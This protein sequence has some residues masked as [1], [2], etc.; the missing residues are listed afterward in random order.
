MKTRVE[1]IDT[2]ISEEDLNFRESY[3]EMK[4]IHCGYEEEMPTECYGEEAI[5]VL[6]ELMIAHE[7]YLP[8]FKVKI[9]ELK[10]IGI[11]IEDEVVKSLM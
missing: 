3:I 5:K 9:E 6:H 2:M 8:Q 4:C 1:T 10:K 11:T 7:K